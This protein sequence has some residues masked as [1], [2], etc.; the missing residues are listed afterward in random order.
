MLPQW[1][2]NSGEDQ[3]SVFNDGRAGTSLDSD[4][5]VAPCN[6]DRIGL[7]LDDNTL[8]SLDGRTVAAPDGDRTGASLDGDR[9][10]AR[11]YV[12]RTGSLLN[13]GRTV[14]ECLYYMVLL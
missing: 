8:E 14:E 9:T 11:I 1:F 10:V 12:S 3:K 7:L 13:G 2:V 5:T 6:G 4:R